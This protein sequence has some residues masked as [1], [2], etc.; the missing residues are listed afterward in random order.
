MSDLK[1]LDIII[2]TIMKYTNMFLDQS[3]YI[4]EN[5]FKI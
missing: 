2:L 5:S 4:N 1:D 3:I